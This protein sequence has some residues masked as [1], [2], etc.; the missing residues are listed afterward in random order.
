MP[1]PVTG[2]PP[3]LGQCLGQVRHDF[4]LN[5]TLVVGLTAVL[6][7]RVFNWGRKTSPRTPRIATVT[8][9]GGSRGWLNKDRQVEGP[10]TTLQRV[11]MDGYSV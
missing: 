7:S 9:P 6:V 4:N 1:W 3:A 11:W 5:M 2:G 8:T 10:G